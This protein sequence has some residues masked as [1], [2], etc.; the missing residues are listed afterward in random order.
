MKL[1][2]LRN[3]LSKLHRLLVLVAV[4][5]A[6]RLAVADNELWVGIPGTSATTNWSDTLNWSGASAYP[7]NNHVLFGNNGPVLVG[8]V[9]NVVD[10]STN[11]LS[12][13]FTNIST[14]HTTLIQPGQT[15]TITGTT[16]L[17][18]GI[19]TAPTAALHMLP[20]G[21]AITTNTITG[22]NGTLLITGPAAGGVYVASTN[23][24]LAGIAPVL[25]LSGLGTFIVSNTAATAAM[26]IGSGA[27]NSDGVLFL[28]MTNFLSLPTNGTGN[29]SALILGD[30]TSANGA[31][32]GGVL[33]LGITNTILADNIGVG[34]SRQSA[35]MMRFN[36]VFTNG[37][38]NPYVSLRGFSTTA[39]KRLAIGDGLAQSGT[40]VAGSGN[41]D[42][43]NGTVNAL[44]TALVLGRPAS[45]SGTNPASIGTLSFS[46]GNI[47]VVNL[48]N[49]MMTAVSGFAGLNP[50]TNQTATGTI[51]ITGTG[52]LTANSVVMAIYLGTAG[53]STGTLNVTNGTLAVGS[54]AVGTG[55]SIVNVNSGTFIVT[56][57]AGTPAAPL[58]A[59]NLTGGTLQLSLNGSSIVSNIVATTVGTSGTTT[60]TIGSVANVSGLTTFPLISYT[61][62]NPFS[63]L[64]LTPLT[65]GFSG[66]L[67][68]NSANNRIDLLVSPPAVAASI[69]WVGATNA[70]LT[71][72]WDT[73]TTNWQDA[74][75]LVP[76]AYADLD[77]L[78]FDDTAS[79]NVVTLNTTAA[80]FSLLV[81]NNALNYTFNGTG[82]ISG[83]TSLIKHGPGTLT[84]AES[85]GDSFNG[86]IV[87]SNGTLVLD[88]AGSGISGG[89][90][91]VAGT[92][93]VGLNDANGNLPG[94][95]I[96]NNG[97]LVFSRTDD[98]AL[99]TVISGTGSL[100][101]KNNSTLTLSGANSFAGGLLANGGTVRLG[102]VGAPGTGNITVTNGATVVL[103]VSNIVNNVLL[104]GGTLGVSVV[105]NPF[106]PDVTAVAG[107]TSTLLIADPNTLGA[108]DPL[109]VASTNVWHGSGTVIVAGV[110]ND[111]SPD[112]GAG[113]RFRTTGP[114]DF[115]GTVILAKGIKGEIQTSVA[116][117]YSPV[118]T[119]KIVITAGVLTNNTVNGSFS[120]LNLRNLSGGSTILGNNIAI[121]GAGLA[122]VDPLSGL[123]GTSVTMGNLTIGGGQELGVDVNGAGSTV[124]FQSATLTGGT[125]TFSP[126]TPG[127]NTAPQTSADLSLGS[128]SELSPSSIMMNGLRTLF[129][130]G[131]NT[132]SGTTTISNGVLALTGTATIA[133][134][135]G[136]V[137]GS[138]ATFDVSGL[139]SAF[140]LGA[141]Q[142][143]S[144]T[145]ATG[146]IAGNATLTAGSVALNYT[147]GTATLAVTNGTLSLNNNAVT[148]TVIG[149]ALPAG[150]YKL[151]SAPT[152]GAVAGAVASSPVTVLGAGFASGAL[153][154][155]KIVGGELYLVVNHAPTANNASYS[156][157][158]VNSWQIAVPNLLTNAADADGDPLTLSS[159]GT[160]TNGVTLTIAGGYV[161]YVNTNLVN[162]QF[163]YTVADG[164][165]G[166]A[167]ATVTLVAAPF[168][169]GQN[170]SVT[171][172]GST[173]TVEFAGIPGY[174]YEV[175]RSTNLVN[176]VNILTTNTPSNGAFSVT[177]NFSD[178]GTIPSS[179][180]Y[181]MSWNGN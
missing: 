43:R 100:T 47:S 2:A 61:G 149:T 1:T 54:I 22:A 56:N 14:T 118:G 159:V 116:G 37:G 39:V 141:G 142:T 7:K 127:W 173:A 150:S 106:R 162:D 132:Y 49:A 78:R 178:L 71:S 16:I 26:W 93:Q 137:I 34:L 20:L 29:A 66:T 3:L 25:D 115:S 165:G 179:A 89:L 120:E 87:V 82:K 48:T 177:D 119:G 19:S 103:V 158:S 101:K 146:L 10:T 95:A 175:E 68:D 28:A 110:T 6:T 77:A 59:L 135:P 148:V 107:T 50:A 155:L 35:A 114:S 166:S 62:A 180:Y 83:I 151:I 86:G 72:S 97:A 160:S 181:R 140:T 90:N 81:T 92:V 138:G 60:I 44:I 23:A 91:I 84:L 17:T 109:E 33:N 75:T 32:P 31:S 174:K 79:N 40:S 167:T 168:V 134:S 63:S 12:L 85:G 27:R 144:G 170:A 11:C 64:T 80:P 45:A 117:P 30:N 139:S 108:T 131:N 130:S 38:A 73:T 163:A 55:T 8:T 21:Q 102:T 70:V 9:N 156:R 52:T 69:V 145:G 157:G 46:A 65:G 112:S 58:T 171:V 125:I 147:N 123:A 136:I 51:N 24:S 169:S 96:V 67:V 161:T 99:S 143:L 152:G 41:V 105:Q 94:G 153:T 128:I 113:F 74:T 13:N 15:L 164:N 36:P 124:V 18:N 76:T 172:S 104:A 154:T 126:K 133:N 88:N 98:L 57:T 5:F 121:S 129:L 111:V 42:F 4:V 122:V 176:W 53:T